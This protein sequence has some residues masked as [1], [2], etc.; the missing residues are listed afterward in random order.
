M[1]SQPKLVWACHS[2]AQACLVFYFYKEVGALREGSELKNVPKRWEKSI[3][4]LPPPHPPPGFVGL[5]EFA[6]K[7]EFD[8]PLPPS[9]LIWEKLIGKILNFGNPPLKNKSLKHPSYQKIHILN[10]GFFIS[11]ADSPPSW[12]FSN[13]DSSLSGKSKYLFNPSLSES[14]AKNRWENTSDIYP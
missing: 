14:L 13:L 3:I 7:W 9:H 4:F 2:S 6:Q 5:F 8:D 10:C 1:G 12:T 11:C